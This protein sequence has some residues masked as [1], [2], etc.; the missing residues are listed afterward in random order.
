MN[1]LQLNIL[2]I[3]LLVELL[4]LANEKRFLNINKILK[5]DFEPFFLCH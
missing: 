2:N 1:I 5:N 4:S 3:A